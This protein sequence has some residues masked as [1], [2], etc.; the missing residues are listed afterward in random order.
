MTNLIQHG[1]G[2]ACSQLSMKSQ[3]DESRTEQHFAEYRI[4]HFGMH[5][6]RHIWQHNE[7]R[8]RRFQIRGR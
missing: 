6:C 2:R 7:V 3:A 5:M 8:N 1:H 4:L